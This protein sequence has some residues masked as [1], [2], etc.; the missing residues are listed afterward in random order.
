MDCSRRR[1]RRWKQTRT[2]K[3][4]GVMVPCH[5]KCHVREGDKAPVPDTAF[6]PPSP[7]PNPRR[8]KNSWKTPVEHSKKGSNSSSHLAFSF[9]LPFM[10]LSFIQTVRK[11]PFNKG[12]Y[13]LQQYVTRTQPF[14]E[15][16]WTNAQKNT[17]RKGEKN[18]KYMTILLHIYI[19]RN[20]RNTKNT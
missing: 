1:G 19:S 7:S 3:M 6:P 2:V 8:K 10:S 17:S 13:P 15:S 16:L 20:G 11:E 9:H 14:G 18:T 12:H 5:Q 4:K